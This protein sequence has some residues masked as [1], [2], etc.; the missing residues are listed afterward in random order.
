MLDKTTAEKAVHLFR[1]ACTAKPLFQDHPYCDFL[2]EMIQTIF[3]GVFHYITIISIMTASPVGLRPIVC[4]LLQFL[5]LR[6][7]HTLEK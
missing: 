2:L 1:F 4:T 3:M 7:S 5:F 6:R